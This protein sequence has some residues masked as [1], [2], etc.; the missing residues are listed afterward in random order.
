MGINPTTDEIDELRYTLV[1]LL[2]PAAAEGVVV[3]CAEV[4]PKTGCTL[5]LQTRLQSGADGRPCS[6]AVGELPL[7]VSGRLNAVPVAHH[8]VTQILSA[9]PPGGGEAPPAITNPNPNPPTLTPTP[10]LT[11]TLT[12]PLTLTRR[13]RASQR[14]RACS[15]TTRRCAT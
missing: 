1:W 11:L 7:R 10:T 4:G 8:L 12:L 6:V 14:R 5:A 15:S 9:P 2:S 3:R 13:R